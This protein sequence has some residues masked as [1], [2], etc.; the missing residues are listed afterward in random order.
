MKSDFR[1]FAPIGLW[2]AGI[3]A[4]VSLGLYIVQ[5][6]FKL[7]LQISLGMIILGLAAF[8]LL[9]PEKVRVALTGRQARH[10]SNALVLT[11]AFIGILVV[12]NYLVIN[13][14]KRWDLTEDKQNTLSDETLQA[15]DALPG[16]VVVQGFF[17]PERNTAIAEDLLKT[18]QLNANDK[19]SYEF[20]DPLSDPIAAQEAEITK[21]GSIVFRMG[22]RKEIVTT[23]NEREFTGGL[24]R[25]LSERENKVYFLTG[26]GEY[27]PEETGD[28]GYSNA[29]RVLESK[30]YEV[31]LLSL[32]S[33]N[34]IPEDASLI[35]I[36]GPLHPLSADEISLLSIYVEEGGGLIVMEEPLLLT[37]FGDEADLLAE[38]LVETWN[39]TLGDDIVLDLTSQQPYVSFAY[40]YGEHPITQKME[41]VSSAF[42]TIRSVQVGAENNSATA[43][44]LTAPQSWAEKDLTD[45]LAGNEPNLDATDSVGPVSIA[46]VAEDSSGG[47]RLAV[48]GD[49]DFATNSN[50][51]YLGN[52][53]L[54]VNT[55]DWVVGQEDLISLTPKENIQRFMPPPQPYMMNLIFL[56]AVFVL[57]GSALIAGIVVWVQ[58][59]RRG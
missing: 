13:N 55:V 35:I 49:A 37:E 42:L 33:T 48:F 27:S 23:I 3:A 15:L 14:A 18:Y 10:G 9:D 31:A 53:D 16:D 22:D 30:N 21:D 44:V 19:L 47:G 36:A 1:R 7:P 54:F 34:D 43:L 38:Y 6:Q 56:G 2:I 59:R 32:I 17:S 41:Q 5:R 39:I 51:T 11:L 57:P 40:Q 52:G 45:L 26:H 29:Q 28:S 20:I 4:L 50:F 8:V 12:I 46:A 24:I 25:L 58:K